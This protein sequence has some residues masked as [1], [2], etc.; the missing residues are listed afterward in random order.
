MD[1][2]AHLKGQGHAAQTHHKGEGHAAQTLLS[3]NPGDSRILSSDTPVGFRTPGSKDSALV[4]SHAP[5]GWL[6]DRAEGLRAQTRSNTENRDCAQP[7][8]PI[9]KGLGEAVWENHRLRL[10]PGDNQTHYLPSHLFRP[11]RLESFPRTCVGSFFDTGCVDIRG[12]QQ[13]HGRSLL[14]L[15]TAPATAV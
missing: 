1:M 6:Y 5:S 8:A 14:S 11:I 10:E 7:R 12:V 4:V 13:S 2:L 15:W 3:Y 9:Y